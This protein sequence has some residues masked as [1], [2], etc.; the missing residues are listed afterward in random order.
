[1]IK[2]TT[3]KEDLKTCEDAVRVL[4]KWIRIEWE[5]HKDKSEDKTRIAH[6]LYVARAVFEDLINKYKMEEIGTADGVNM[7]IK[8]LREKGYDQIA[9]EIEK[10]FIEKDII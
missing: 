1:M 7:T 6:C 4:N 9:T 2:R 8:L 5:D 3:I 10:D